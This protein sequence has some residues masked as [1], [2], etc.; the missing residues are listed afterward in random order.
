MTSHDT[1]LTESPQ[2]PVKQAHIIEETSELLLQVCGLCDESS[3][4]KVCQ[5]EPSI[6]PARG[7][8]P[9]NWCAGR[10]CG[11]ACCSAHCKG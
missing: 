10:T 1:L 2:G 11:A 4:E 5:T 7:E 3:S 8:D 6:L 9:H